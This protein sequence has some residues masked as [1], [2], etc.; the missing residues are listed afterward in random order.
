ME[1][2]NYRLLQSYCT[3]GLISTYPYHLDHTYSSG[4]FLMEFVTRY[5]SFTN[6]KVSPSL[7]YLSKDSIITPMLVSHVLMAPIHRQI[8]PSSAVFPVLPTPTIPTKRAHAH[9]VILTSTVSQGLLIV[10][11]RLLAPA[12]HTYLCTLRALTILVMSHT[13]SF[14]RTYVLVGLYHRLTQR[15]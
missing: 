3:T 4:V 10:S 12:L 9:H 14:F 7:I 5:L 15:E 8:L 1:F 2:L 13:R 11:I 6:L